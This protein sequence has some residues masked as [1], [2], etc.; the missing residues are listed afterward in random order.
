MEIKWLGHACFLI[1]SPGGTRVVTDPINEEVGYA[2]QPVKAD[3]VT[4]SHEHFDHNHVP[5][6]TGSP[7]VVRALTSGG[8]DWARPVEKVGDVA[9]STVPTY[10]DPEQGAKRGKNG[11]FIF[12]MG[13][14]RMAHL[15]DL[16]H[17]LSPEQGAEFGKID[18][19]L[20][21]VGGFYTIGPAEAD[22][23]VS[24]LKPRVAIPM[25]VK[26]AANASWPIESVEA[27]LRG[28]AGVRR[29]GNSLVQ[30]EPGNLP[31]PTEYWVLEPAWLPA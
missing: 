29:V 20:I 30:V 9:V 27:F 18:V 15:G 1:T 28:K 25:H 13:S 17:P 21:P 12:D 22:R 11:C 26:T 23:V 6:V 8:A 31:L 2:T 19:L 10:H 3:L 5:L 24:L 4:V 7:R 16:G 14:I